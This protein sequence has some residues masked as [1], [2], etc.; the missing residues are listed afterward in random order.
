[1]VKGASIRFKS[2]EETLPKVLDLFKVSREL[3]KYDK[4]VIKPFLSSESEKSTSLEL[5][6]SILKF[7]LAHKNPVAEIYI[8]EGVDGEDTGYL[9]DALGYRKLT[10]K[11]NVGLVDLNDA[12]TSEIENDSFIKFSTIEFPKILL[13]SFLI[14]VTKLSHDE[15]TEITGSL[16][17]MLGAFPSSKYKGFFSTKKNKIRKWPIKYSI[18]D[19]IKCKLPDF[20]VIDASD[21]GFILAGL[22]F[23]LDKNAAKLLEK[24]WQMVPYLNLIHENTP[25]EEESKNTKGIQ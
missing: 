5:I 23:E 8:A 24:N 2:Y 4:I 11:Y 17:N 15:E 25:K 19:I 14:S 3:K 22:P 16:S 12:E 7:C 21:K 18:Y 9:F 13:N 20:A 6:E 10:E 1:M